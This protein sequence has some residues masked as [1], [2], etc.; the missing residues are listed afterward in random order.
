MEIC[1]AVN[2]VLSSQHLRQGVLTLGV[3]VDD[4]VGCSPDRDVLGLVAADDGCD[5]AAFFGSDGEAGGAGEGGAG[6]GEDRALGELVGAGE[7]LVNDHLGVVSGAYLR[8]EMV[9]GDVL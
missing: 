7:L 1:N 3:G 2:L 4:R 9:L 8:G 6:V 5:G